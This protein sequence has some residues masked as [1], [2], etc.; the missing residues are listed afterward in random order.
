MNIKEPCGTTFI[1]C[2]LFFCILIAC[3]NNEVKWSLKKKV[4]LI[5]TKNLTHMLLYIQYLWYHS[6]SYEINA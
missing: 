5:S 1:N 2:D 6:N 3:M 4:I